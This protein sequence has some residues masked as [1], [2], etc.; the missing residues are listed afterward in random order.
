LELSIIILNWNAA[1][2]TIRCVRHITAWRQLQAT[3][4]VVDNGSPD[5]S[6]DLIARECPGI[7]L[8][9]NSANLGYAGGNNKAIT[10][11]LARSDAP[12]LFLNNDASVT[13]D[14]VIQLMKTLQ[15][16]PQFGF[17]GPLLFET[18]REDRLL[19]AG[20]RNI[21]LHLT[22]H[23][24]KVTPGEPIGLVDYVP[25]T[26]MLARAEV[27]RL[28]GLLDDAFFFTGEMPDLCYR[29]RQRGFLSA[30]DTRARAFH[31][32]NRSSKLRQTLYPYYIVRNRFLFLRKHYCWNILLYSFWVL[33]SLALALKVQ[34]QGQSSIARAIGLGLMD[35]LRGQFGGQNERVLVINSKQPVPDPQV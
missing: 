3:I 30:V 18:G 31:E 10:K 35:G 29:A 5:G 28:V 20:G 9:R 22:S 6:V 32:V 4:W 1:A 27:F 2:D 11:A 23:L 14:D 21:V 17:V 7:H 15:A 33:Y 25:G 24:S 12:I 34:L 8:I 13:E 16:N 19:T 26:V